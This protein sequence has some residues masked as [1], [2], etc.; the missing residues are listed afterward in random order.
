MCTGD[1]Y[2]PRKRRERHSK[3]ADSTAW[4]VDLSPRRTVEQQI[5]QSSAEMDCVRC[6][7]SKFQSV[8]LNVVRRCLAFKLLDQFAG[9]AHCLSS[10]TA[11]GFLRGRARRQ[12]RGHPLHR[13]QD[14]CDLP[15]CSFVVVGWKHRGNHTSLKRTPAKLHQTVKHDHAQ[16]LRCQAF[17][18][19]SSSPNTKFSEESHGPRKFHS[20]SQTRSD[21]ALVPNQ[22]ND[23]NLMQIKI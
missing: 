9:A 10:I 12:D 13:L 14:V 7:Q 17:L 6:R 15:S 18:R 16:K 2:H 21:L 20:T 19:G 8:N 5:R 1:D 22:R 11:P 23:S 4:C 3:E